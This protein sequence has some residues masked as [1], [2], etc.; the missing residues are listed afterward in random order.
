MSASLRIVSEGMDCW[1]SATSGGSRICKRGD[2]GKDAEHEPIIGVCGGAPSRVPGGGKLKAF[3]LFSNKKGPK[4]KDLNEN[5]PM[6]LRQAA[7]CS[8]DQ[9]P[10]G[11]PPLLPP[12]ESAT[13]CYGKI[14]PPSHYTSML[15]L[16][17]TSLHLEHPENVFQLIRR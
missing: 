6:C 5:L 4:V 9:R 15:S 17:V 16:T 3:C 10:G 12:F 1:H 11:M 8:H 13:E 7:S 2:Y 14:I